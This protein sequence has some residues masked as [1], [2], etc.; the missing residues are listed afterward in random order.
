MSTTLRLALRELRGGV[1]GFYIFIACI[2]LGVMAIAAVGS[3]TRTLTEGL[4]HQGRI[5]LGGDIAF[6]LMQRQ[7]SPAERAFLESRSDVSV[8]A[9]MRA[10]ARTSD[11]RAALVEVKAVD[12]AYPLYGNLTVEPAVDLGVGLSA[13][14]ARKGDVF[15][16]IAERSLLTRLDLQPGA[17][18][19]IGAATFELRAALTGEP[20]KLAGGIGFG[21][22]LMMSDEALAATGLV[23]PGSLVRWI[24]RLR[25]PENAATDAVE[26]TIEAANA[27]FPEAGWEIRSRNNAA[28][29]LERNI[30]RFSQ[31]LVLVGLTAL[32]I[33]GVGV[34]NSARYFLDRKRNVMAIL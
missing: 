1:R 26:Q 5:I 28:P 24:Y 30:E 25:L 17:R 15:G 27:Q 13:M 8:A 6:S 19:T 12:G 7:V 18:V 3:L 29:Q 10:M 21:P 4:A 34:A 9:A 32:L 20:D 16:A 23:Q 31:Y 2:A 22:R 11:G 33:G 14:L